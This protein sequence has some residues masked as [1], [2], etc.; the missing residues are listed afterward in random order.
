MWL[1]RLLWLG[2]IWPSSGQLEKSYSDYATQLREHLKDGLDQLV[3]PKSD[4]AVNY[5]KAGTDV[6]M[7]I[8]FFK[9][10]G[11]D[12]SA[13][14]MRLK[15]WVRL[16]WIDQRL[17]W[18][19]AAFGNVS[20]V[21][22]YA[23]DSTD[24]EGTEIWVPDIQLYNSN[25]GTQASLDKSTAMV[26]SDGSVFWSRPGL[27][28]SLCKFSGLVAFPFD[29]LKCAMEWG[30]WAFSDGFQGIGIQGEGYT[31]L[32]S[33]DTA[34][35]SYQ[36][37]SI[38][39]VRVDVK[40]T[41]Y[42]A[43]PEHPWT[44]VK[45]TIELNRASFYYDLLVILPTVLI[46]YLSFGV[47]FMSFEVGERLSFGITLLLVVEVMKA[48]V[49]TF[50][51]VCGETLWVDLFML[52]N[53][54]FCCTSLLET[55]AV[56][57]FAFHMDEHLL[58]SWLAWMAPWM[59]CEKDPQRPEQSQAGSIYRRLIAGVKSGSKSEAEDPTSK[60]SQ[61]LKE[62]EGLSETDT[63]KLIFFENLFYLTDSG[64]DG[65][66]EVE[67]ACQMLSFVNLSMSRPT[68]E[69]F[70]HEKW[71]NH[72]DG[73]TCSD[74]MEICLEL[75]W[76]TPFEEIRMGAENYNSSCSRRT[77]LNSAYWLSWSKAIDRWARFWLP[78]LYTISLGILF[79]LE[80][81]DDYETGGSTMFQGFGP[82]FV[83]AAGVFRM[84][85][86]PFFGLV[87]I[88]AWVYMKRRAMKKTTRSSQVQ[89]EEDTKKV[90]V[91]RWSVK[92]PVTTED[93]E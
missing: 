59:L 86:M 76:V 26:Y 65:L 40:T 70:I 7:S 20:Q 8:R 82:V 36:E 21:N 75:M 90:V 6:S 30:G 33:E 41:F 18:D 38:K 69:A 51:P 12:A 84:L 42:E 56:L 50:I 43:V 68:L 80:F 45:Y 66:I 64:H 27:L 62:K 23:G 15:V 52:V 88:A 2:F 81:T 73:L 34:G 74:F 13:G 58:P 53:T 28:D 48:T 63:A 11:V 14:Q 83:T 57:F 60:I 37:Y 16:Q 91:P 93:I 29:K 1:R 87:C 72:K 49:A 77:R 92:Q 31:F 32:N 17:S 67:E 25:V 47:F 78:M 44:I 79:N 35:A 61:Q 54:A 22:F 39:A 4:R 71:P 5:S 85:V 24:A 55:M 10:Q 19:P 3:P 9:V 46:T 89:P